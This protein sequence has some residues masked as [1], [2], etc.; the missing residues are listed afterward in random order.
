MTAS[1]N[2]PANLADFIVA[3]VHRQTSEDGIRQMVEK[4]IG[5]AVESAV[6][7]AFS[8]GDVGKQIE[9]AV[10][11][12][13]AIGG[14]IDV[15]A[16]G[17]M[18]MGL[19]RAKMDEK[20]SALVNERLATEMDEILSLAPKELKLTDVVEALREEIDVQDRYGSS[21]TCIVEE[22]TAVLGYW[23]IY[24]DKEQKTRKHECE[25]QFAI[26]S[27]GRIY[28]LTC[29][30]KD[31]KTVIVMGAMHGFKKMVFAAYC[32]GSKFIVDDAEPSTHIGDY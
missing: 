5:E 2:A 6:K 4:K 27:E 28:S 24:L 16:Y 17:N 1:T 29:D 30:R 19:L 21:F 11:A 22:S 31:A 18:V 13:L 7:A 23:H 12:S 25:L 20:L 14:R 9:K 26:C 3:E 10:S 8:W 15:P 32:C